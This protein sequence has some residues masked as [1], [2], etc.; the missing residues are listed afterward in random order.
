MKKLIAVN[1]QMEKK[2]R[3]K[4]MIVRPARTIQCWVLKVQVIMVSFVEERK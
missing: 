2:K 1:A 3:R 4:R